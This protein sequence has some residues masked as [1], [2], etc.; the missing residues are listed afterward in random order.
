MGLC[1]PGAACLPGSGCANASTGPE[2]G[3]VTSSCSCNSSGYLECTTVCTDGG[4]ID[5]A[6]DAD[7][8]P[9]DAAADVDAGDPCAGYALPNLC[10]VCSDG[11]TQC[12]HFVI[13]DGQCA[14]EI[15]P[16]TPTMLKTF[17]ALP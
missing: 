12:E 16:G 6:P 17:D 10:E 2:P 4:A 5:A 9:T 11:S 7:A 14:I 3:C 15:C 1:E 8:E 13:V